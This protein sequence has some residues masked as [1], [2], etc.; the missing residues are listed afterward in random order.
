[1]TKAI[2]HT[3]DNGSDSPSDYIQF[4][5]WHVIL[6]RICKAEA[7]DNYPLFCCKTSLKSHLQLLLLVSR[8]IIISMIKDCDLPS[9]RVSEAVTS[10]MLFSS[11]FTRT[12]T[13][14]GH[15]RIPLFPL[16]D[17]FDHVCCCPYSQT[18]IKMQATH[19]IVLL[20]GLYGDVHNLHAVK[21]ELLALADPEASTISDNDASGA[22][23]HNIHTSNERPK[24]SLETVV[25]LP[26][27]IKGVHTWDGID[28]CAHRVA[29]EVRS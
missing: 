1:M 27:S 18:D 11:S 14:A 21:S 16:A 20:H 13:A 15:P 10:V 24:K 12:Y 2:K 5:V 4:T 9:L 28:V 26:K 25:Y 3:G 29:E 6:F 7:V 8:F 22:E 17:F 19:L 23:K